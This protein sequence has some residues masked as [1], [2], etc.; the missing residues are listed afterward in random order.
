MT[1]DKRTSD[2]CPMPHWVNKVSVI[3]KF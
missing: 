2:M 1:Q 3:W